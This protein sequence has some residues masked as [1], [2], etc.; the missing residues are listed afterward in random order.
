MLPQGYHATVKYF[1]RG[2]SGVDSGEQPSTERMY[3]RVWYWD[4]DPMVLYSVAAMRYSESPDGV[5]WHNDQPAQNG[6]VEIVTGEVPD[7]NRGTYGPCDIIFD[8]RADAPFAM[9]YNGTTGGDEAIGLAHSTDGITWTGYDGDGDGSADPVF[10]G[11]YTAGDW[12]F[13]YVGRAT[14]VRTG[15]RRYEMWYSGGDG[16]LNQGIG[17][18]VSRDG[19]NWVR[20]AGNPIFH[21]DDGVAWR[22]ERSYTPAALPW[23]RNS[24]KMWFAGRSVGKTSIGYAV[25]ERRRYP[26]RLAAALNGD[27]LP[28]VDRDSRLAVSTH[29]NPANPETAVRIR[30]SVA[31]RVEIDLFDVLGRRVRRLFD[32][33][34]QSGGH[35]L[36]WDGRDNG[37]REASS[38]VYFYSVFTG[39]DR[40]TG[41]I[42]L[43]R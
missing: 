21:V 13:D 35:N 28:D 24:Y 11:T 41:Q 39:S 3:Y 14:V 43:L 36:V 27:H 23:K 15:R 4:P 16:A 32:G 26:S 30:L 1:R 22:T 31:S 38:G 25:G 40:E 37:G 20:D 19:R 7:W 10:S 12:D 29:P 17:Y 9:Y 33:R 8:P 18:A 2:F 34:L 5:S 6:A 42:T